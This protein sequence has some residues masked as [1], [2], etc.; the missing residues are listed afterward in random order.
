MLF[1]SGFGPDLK[2]D[3]VALVPS[4]RAKQAR[5]LVVPRDLC[6]VLAST[7]CTVRVVQMLVKASGGEKVTPNSG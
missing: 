5:I 7:A 2:D 6:S 1:R 4:K 3:V